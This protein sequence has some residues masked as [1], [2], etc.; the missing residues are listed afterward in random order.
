M[1]NAF[2]GN[3]WLIDTAASTAIAPSTAKV[4]I[5]ALRWVIAASG[6][7][8]DRCVVQDGAGNAITEFINL[9]VG[10]TP[11]YTYYDTGIV[12]M[13]HSANQFNGFLVPTLTHGKLYVYLA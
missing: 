5:R 12:E 11:V 8:A 3:V 13:P 9:G 2:S 1:A 4:I 10:N 6:A 7:A